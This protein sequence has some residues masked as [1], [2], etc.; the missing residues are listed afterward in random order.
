MKKGNK[1]MTYFTLA[2]RE[3]DHWYIAFGDYE[4]DVVLDEMEEYW[5]LERFDKKVIKTDG[6]QLSI[7]N[8]IADLNN[9]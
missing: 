8:A 5:H 4:R 6:N 7:E 3:N 2:V 1:H 9:Y